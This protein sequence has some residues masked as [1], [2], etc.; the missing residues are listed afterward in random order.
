ME[1]EPIV[2]ERF[3]VEYFNAFAQAL[4]EVQD[5][6]LL[7][8][9]INS[10][11]GT[12][13]IGYTLCEYLHFDDDDDDD[14][15]DCAAWNRNNDRYVV[16]F[17]KNFSDNLDNLFPGRRDP[18]VWPF[19]IMD[20]SEQLTSL[21]EYYSWLGTMPYNYAVVTTNNNEEVIRLG[22]DEIPGIDLSNNSFY[23]YVLEVL[24]HLKTLKAKHEITSYRMGTC[25]RFFLDI[26]KHNE[27]A[28]KAIEGASDKFW[29][30]IGDI[31]QNGNEVT[32]MD[33]FDKRGGQIKY[34]KYDRPPKTNET[35][36]TEDNYIRQEAIEIYNTIIT[37]AK[38]NLDVSARSELRKKLSKFLKV[39]RHTIGCHSLPKLKA[40]RNALLSIPPLPVDTTDKMVN[41][42]NNL[43]N[44]IWKNKLRKITNK[45]NVIEDKRCHYRPVLVGGASDLSWTW[46]CIVQG[47]AVVAA[48]TVFQ[49][50]KI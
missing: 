3:V 40:A 10:I 23:N 17:T 19:L 6:I 15:D 31:L 45:I 46:V 36:E 25:P 29:N 32:D 12:H 1:D 18:R 37:R 44:R 38:Q 27:D 41:K 28:R 13:H 50:L 49:S 2:D 42:E 4:Q 20:Y 33:K 9:N 5:P 48:A 34:L 7:V 11:P 35:E 47:L 30:A 16:N 26:F 22:I 14:D 43:L 39:R 24:R 8:K 21:E